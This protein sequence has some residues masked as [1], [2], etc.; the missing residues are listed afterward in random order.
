MGSYC[1]A[2][3]LARF[4]E[5]GGPGQNSRP[6]DKLGLFFH[7]DLSPESQSACIPDPCSRPSVLRTSLQEARGER[8]HPN[9]GLS[10]DR[11]HV[12]VCGLEAGGTRMRHVR[13]GESRHA[14]RAHHQGDPA[15]E[16]GPHRHQLPEHHQLPERKDPGTRDPRRR[17]E[18]AGRLRRGLRHAQRGARQAAVPGGELRLPWRR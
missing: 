9:H 13:S 7:F 16:A 6:M 12:P 3:Y 5:Q 14:Q 18:G 1:C 11:N 15:T 10:A 4:H 8:Q 17:F 2:G